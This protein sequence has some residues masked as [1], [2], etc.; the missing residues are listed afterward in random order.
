[1]AFVEDR[2]LLELSNSPK[3][4]LFPV[5]NRAEAMSPWI[6]LLALIPPLYV[7]VNRT[8][9]PLD[10]LWGLKAVA[11]ASSDSPSVWLDPAS[12]S[13][14]EKD[15]PLKWQPPLSSWLVAGV[16]RQTATYRPLA[17]VLV[18]LFATSGLIV[19]VFGLADRLR[20]PE[21]AWW[22]VCLLALHGPVLQ[23]AQTPAPVS[24]ALTFAVAACW[25]FVAHSQDAKRLFSVQ[26]GWGGVALG[27]CFLAG[28]PI[29]FVVVA[30]LLLYLLALSREAKLPKKTTG[31]V[32]RAWKGK[33]AL[34]SLALM[35]GIGI[36]IGGWWTIWMFY[37]HGQ[38]FLS[39]WFV[40]PSYLPAGSGRVLERLLSD[41][42]QLGGA[43]IGLIGLGGW[44]GVKL[45]RQP[46]V[47]SKRPGLALILSW[48]GCAGLVWVCLRLSPH[49]S[50][51]FSVVW[52]GFCLIPAIL[53]AALAIEQIDLRRIGYF[54][55][56]F[57]LCLTIGFL[58]FWPVQIGFGLVPNSELLWQ[59]ARSVVQGFS[60]PNTPWVL[61]L[62]WR[63]VFLLTLGSVISWLMWRVLK[64]N[65]NRQRV[66]L[67]IALGVFFVLHGLLNLWG[68]R[69][70]TLNDQAL[71]KLLEEMV[72]KDDVTRWTIVT[73]NRSPLMLRFVLTSLWPHAESMEINSWYDSQLTDEISRDES[74]E[75]DHIVFDWNDRDLRTPI[76]RVTD[77]EDRPHIVEFP[78]VGSP[79]ILWNHRL[80]IYR[81]FDRPLPEHRTR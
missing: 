73:P 45:L 38:A 67:G 70:T 16:M 2:Q 76:L 52:R 64:N 24:L 42:S 72:A 28:G 43:L 30:I 75:G 4:A 26:L 3:K 58:F 47:E 15:L 7:M 81:L 63:V 36:L 17:L 5:L 40:G 74:S 14:G 1:M 19:C 11:M 31:K 23:G 50:N 62:L 49:H 32:R 41:V 77:P 46:S 34:Q 29:T 20:G 33:A 55:V 61:L 35:L 13:D 51:A 57:G 39:G 37:R 8:L 80:R 10:A 66:F 65:D 69:Q 60:I 12:S 56:L 27:L 22:T 54:G 78:S 68:V 71:S 21:Y 79:Q 9:T 18:S 48:M 6:V 53:L 59:S 44:V 25:G